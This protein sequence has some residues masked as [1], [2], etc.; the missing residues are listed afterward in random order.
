ML[1][2][3]GSQIKNPPCPLLKRGEMKGG[4]KGAVSCVA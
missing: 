4:F 3:H 2:A 1:I